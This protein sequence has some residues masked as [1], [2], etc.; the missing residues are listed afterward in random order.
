M[1][2]AVAVHSEIDTTAHYR[3]EAS[4]A[5]LVALTLGGEASGFEIL[6]HRYRSLFFSLIHTIATN[7]SDA[8]DIF[9][10]AMFR[11]YLKLDTLHEP[12]FFRPWACRVVTNAA[13]AARRTRRRRQFLAP[14]THDENLELLDDPAPGVDAQAHIRELLLL[15]STWMDQLAT[16]ERDILERY[17]WQGQTMQEIAHAHEMTT[18]AVKAHAFRARLFLKAQRAHYFGETT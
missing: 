1:N 7:E 18:A 3:E 8:E 9:Q 14:Q 5:T 11:I 13:L 6:V 2:A 16:H 17:A 15:T 10:Q 4:D 12:A